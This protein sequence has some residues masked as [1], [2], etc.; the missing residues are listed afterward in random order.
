MSQFSG[1]LNA[2][3]P[4]FCGKESIVLCLN[5]YTVKIVFFSLQMCMGSVILTKS[6][7]TA[8]QLVLLNVQVKTPPTPC[9]LSLLKYKVGS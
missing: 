7:E 4:S 5:H 9:D 2:C 8:A 3:L 1:K 6:S